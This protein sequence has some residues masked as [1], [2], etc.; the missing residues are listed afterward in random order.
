M[1]DLMVLDI[2]QNGQNLDVNYADNGTDG[3]TSKV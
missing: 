2:P 3:A 1:E